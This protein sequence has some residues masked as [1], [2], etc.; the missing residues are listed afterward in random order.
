ML[1][2]RLSSALRPLL[3]AR[4]LQPLQPPLASCRLLS[5]R[6]R[7]QERPVERRQGPDGQWVSRAM[8]RMT[9]PGV[10]WDSA[11]VERRRDTDGNLYT[12]SEFQ[13]FHAQFVD[14]SSSDVDGVAYEHWT[15]AKHWT[16]RMTKQIQAEKSTDSLLALHR[17]YHDALDYIHLS[18]LWH[19][20]GALDR[21]QRLRRKPAQLDALREHTLAMMPQF[22]EQA[23]S[24]ISLSLA[25]SGL[26]QKPPWP[27]LW[28]ALGAE[29]QGRVGEFT[30]Q[31]LS[32]TAWAFATAGHTAPA[33]FEA[34]AQQA[35]G[36]AGAFKDQ[37]LSN[38][39]WA[40][41]VADARCDALFGGPH[42]V[43]ACERLET[44]LLGNRNALAQLEVWRQWRDACSVD[45]RTWP[46]LPAP[47]L[48]ACQSAGRKGNPAK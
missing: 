24:N 42:F 38:T 31:A 46:T 6:A 21:S 9:Y 10:A 45:G 33:L 32:N 13:S 11:E 35:Q 8:F 47:L 14:G 40:F 44:S 12:L 3:T 7:P 1:A 28:I 30:E 19:R 4:P 39:A 2:R 16:H 43:Q 25:R 41:V 48:A 22:G 17:D 18:T 5:R 36:R 26:S 29:A 15:E 20:L 37:E 34:I 23:L 27:E